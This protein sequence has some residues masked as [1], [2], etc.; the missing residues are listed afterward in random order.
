MVSRPVT[1]PGENLVRVGL[2]ADVP[3]DLVLRGVEQAVEGD[4][5]LAGPEVSAEVSADLPDHVDDQLA[6]LL[7]HPLQ[8]LVRETGQLC[9][10]SIESISFAA[11]DFG[12]VRPGSSGV[13]CMDEVGYS[14]QVVCADRCPL[15]RRP[16]L[17]V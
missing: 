16:G 1:P 3:E 12:P 4:S 13:S 5:E 2:V 11:A 17:P 6:H 8:L 10:E 15:E 7:R 14:D 9:W